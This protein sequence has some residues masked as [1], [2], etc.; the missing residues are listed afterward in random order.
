MMLIKYIGA[1]NKKEIS[2]HII[3]NTKYFLKNVLLFDI[4]GEKYAILS[5]KICCLLK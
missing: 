1:G 2:K 5:F 4:R 3:Q